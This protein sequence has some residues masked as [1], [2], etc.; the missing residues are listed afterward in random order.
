MAFSGKVALVTGGGSG[1][2]RVMALRLAQAGAKVAI[3]DLNET[4]MAEVAAQHTAISPFVCDVANPADI[5]AVVQKIESTLGPI[6]RLAAAAG[7]MPGGLISDMSAE[8]IARI[9][10][11]NVE[12]TVNT[13]K[14]V[15]P[16]MRNRGR[17][18][19]ILF[20]SLAGVV[21]TQGMGAYNAS[22]AAVNAFGE[23]LAYELR[24]TGVKIATVR[25]SA[26][27]TPLID[28]AT[29]AVKS[30][31]DVAAKGQMAAPETIIDA[32]EKGLARGDMWIYPTADARALQ[33]LRRFSPKLT[34]NLINR[35]GA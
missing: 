26:V 18:E 9:M 30:L 28:Q 5:D 12:G 11:V 4:G 19:I 13:V 1:M 34:W 32:I 27:N 22:K 24:G 33:W 7:I 8:R 31:R 2:G 21:F 3:A 6:D 25:P 10:R 17:G 29:D 35:F 23:V 20:G 14:A 15:L 16:G